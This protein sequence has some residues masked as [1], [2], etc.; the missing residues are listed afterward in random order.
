MS[1]DSVNRLSG[2]LYHHYQKTLLVM[3]AIGVIPVLVVVVEVVPRYIIWFHR[4][5]G[6]IGV[7]I[8][9]PYQS[10]YS[11]YYYVTTKLMLNFM[12]YIHFL[13]GF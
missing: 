9:V 2:L 7:N 6:T 3:V 8:T 13:F 10:V 1:T 5:Q 11:L 4:L 12:N